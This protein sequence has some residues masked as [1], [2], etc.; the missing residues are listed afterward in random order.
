M[1]QCAF[2]VETERSKKLTSLCRD[3]TPAAKAMLDNVVPQPLV[4]LRRP[5]PLPVVHL[6]LVAGPAPHCSLLS[7]SEYLLLFFLQQPVCWSC[8]NMSCCSSRVVPVLSAPCDPLSFKGGS[9][10]LVLISLIGGNE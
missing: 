4:L 8:L 10:I 2:T 1:Q 3:S 6:R 9:H 5:Q 7:F